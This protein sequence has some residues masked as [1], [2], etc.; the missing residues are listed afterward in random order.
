MNPLHT[1]GIAALGAVLSTLPIGPINLWLISL[2]WAKKYRQWWAVMSGIIIAD[3]GIA[4]GAYFL[5]DKLHDTWLVQASPSM[6]LIQDYALGLVMIA[7]GVAMVRQQ[8]KLPSASSNHH[9]THFSIRSLQV[10]GAIAAGALATL[11]QPGL[12]IFWSAWWLEFASN[13]T[14]GRLNLIIIFMILGV[15]IGDILVFGTYWMIA[16]RLKGILSPKCIRL[17]V[18]LMAAVFLIAGAIFLAK[19]WK[20]IF[21]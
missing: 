6:A 7:I 15:F 8:S 5:A 4:L 21:T 14:D 20:G 10:G 11:A 2:C 9:V 3:T 19:A 13:R 18:L 16:R 17:T 12:A 1:S